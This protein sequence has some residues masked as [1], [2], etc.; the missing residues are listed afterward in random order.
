MNRSVLFIV[1]LFVSGC[2]IGPAYQRPATQTPTTWKTAPAPEWQAAVPR[3]GVPRGA[4]WE[5]FQDKTLNLL[6]V[7]AV[8]TN[9]E[10]HAAMAR[11]AQARAIARISTAEWFPTLETNP[12]YDH[13]RR[14]LSGFGGGGGFTND[15]F[16]IPLDLSYELD[17]WGRVRRSFEAATADA[18]ASEAAYH[19]VLL[20]LTADVARAYFEL[21]TLDAELAILQETT[22]LRQDALNLVRRRT[23]AGLVS[24][25]DLARAKTELA[26]AE[27]EGTDVQRRRA[28]LEN[29]LAVLCGQL[30][31][32]FRVVAQPAELTVPQIPA[33]VTSRVLERRPD[34]ADA[35]RRVAAANAR[36]GVAQAASFPVVRLTGSAGLESPKL[37]TLL[38]WDS[39][40][41]SLGP[42]VSIPLFSGG[43][44][45]ANLRATKAEHEAT[46][47][48][49]RQQ[50]VK[51][52]QEVE[53]A[54]ANLQWRAE[55]AQI[56]AR[57]IDSSREAASLSRARYEQGL[58]NYLEVTDTE[59]SRLEAERS[60]LQILNQRL[61]STILLIKALGG[62]WDDDV[63]PEPAS[64]LSRTDADQPPR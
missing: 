61:A 16:R 56:Q 25:L 31:S 48:G 17:L 43:R 2:A 38:E 9:H 10:L 37:E 27:A 58:V 11:V 62:G 51:A 49:Y 20:T 22:K 57:I 46:V 29:A 4:W 14:S 47:A 21:R 24:Q 28:E 64:S 44:N 34:I 6:E 55:Q 5:A 42:S 41:W 53:N 59:R 15:T 63:P 33:G 30:A 50:V 1:S 39:R 54:L 13:F 7:Q 35:E 26:S 12:S 36:I 45:A 8:H 52:F 19:T 32:E 60:A 23:E 40:V 18:Q 3:D